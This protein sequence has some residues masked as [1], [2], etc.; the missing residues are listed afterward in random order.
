M[1]RPRRKKPRGTRVSRPGFGRLALVLGLIAFGLVAAL[2]S[3]P[4]ASSQPTGTEPSGAEP[5]QE[6]AAPDEAHRDLTAVFIDV[7]QGQ[8]VLLELPDGKT[9]LVDAGPRSAE[10]AVEAELASHNVARIDYLVAT[11]ADSDHIGGMEEV[12]GAHEVGEFLTPQTTH[13]TDTYLGLLQAIADRGVETRAAWAGD[14]VASDGGYSVEI[15]SPVEGKEYT[16]S[17]DWSVVLLVTYGNTRMLLTGDAPKEILKGLGIGPVDVLG[18]S[19]HGSS[20]GTDGE[21]AR[22]LSPKF[23]IISYGLDNEYGHPTSEVLNALAATEIYGTGAN[24]AV[25]AISDGDSYIVSG[26]RAG[27]VVAGDVAADVPDGN[28]ASEVDASAEEAVVTTPKGKR[29]HRRGCR[30]L[31]G[32][33]ALIERTRSEAEGMGLTACGVCNP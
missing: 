13:T 27:E 19:H 30:T 33:K 3:R 16:E 23:S 22:M 20:T 14:E 2:G 29:Y 9:M 21:L 15:L 12:V 10:T 4:S 18:V 7:G 32:S 5:T 31:S 17:N 25:T 8:A 6:T 28:S 26:E 1:G 11:H 24:G